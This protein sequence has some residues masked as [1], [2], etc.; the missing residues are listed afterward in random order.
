M[1]EKKIFFFSKNQFHF[2]EKFNA[3]D[4][5]LQFMSHVYN[6]INEGK[7]CSGSFVDLIKKHLIE[8]NILYCYPG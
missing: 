5:L 7:F 6:G 1:S 8:W 3:N 4:A 2:R